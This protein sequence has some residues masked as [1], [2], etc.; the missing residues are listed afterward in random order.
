MSTTVEVFADMTCPFAHVGLKAVARHV[1]EQTSPVSVRVRAWPLEWVNGSPL[2]AD[3]VAVKAAAL[4]LQLG[5]DDFAHFTVEAW[6]ISTIPALNLAGMAYGVDDATGFAVSLALRAA[7][8]EQG[9]NIAERTVLADVA[10]AHGLPTGVLASALDVFEASE[11]VRSD[12]ALGLARGVKGSPHF[13][14][15]RD[16]FFCPA[17]DLG[18]DAAGQLTARFDQAALEDFFRRLDR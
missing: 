17:L 2:D 7:L 5:V 1:A 9:R 16:D 13:W 3:A 11:S 4:T 8:F 15:E 14:V 18:H 6:P 12:Y 10:A